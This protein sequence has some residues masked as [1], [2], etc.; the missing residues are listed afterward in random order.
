MHGASWWNRYRYQWLLLHRLQW[1]TS[2]SR[3]GLS[4][5]CLLRLSKCFRMPPNRKQ[6]AMVPWCDHPTSDRGRLMQYRPC[7]GQPRL[8][9]QP[10]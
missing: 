6:Q 7:R 10:R 2:H 5:K 3:P 1:S 4:F 8:Q 9:L